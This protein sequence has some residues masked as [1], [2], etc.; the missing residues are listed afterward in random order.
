MFFF[1]WIRSA[2]RG[3]GLL[4][5]PYPGSVSLEGSGLGWNGIRVSSA[6]LVKKMNNLCCCNAVRDLQEKA[7]SH[8]ESMMSWHFSC[9]CPAKRPNIYKVTRISITPRSS[10]DPLGQQRRL[11]LQRAGHPHAATHP[12]PGHNLP[13][14]NIPVGLAVIR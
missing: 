8:E 14:L 12:D 5:G 4:G 11:A 3:I 10:I 6:S 13:C 1:W 7:R 2:Q 9:R